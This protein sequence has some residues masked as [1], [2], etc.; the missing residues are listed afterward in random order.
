MLSS[1]SQNDNGNYINGD[2]SNQGMETDTEQ[3]KALVEEKYD[4]SPENK[5]ALDDALHE[6]DQ[7][8]RQIFEKENE[9]EPEEITS[10]IENAQEEYQKK[11]ADITAGAE[12]FEESE[13]DN[14]DDDENNSGGFGGSDGVWGDFF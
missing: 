12:E 8:I 7:K 11:L 4:L 3:D 2:S 9:L 1:K 10:A 13:S 5:K 14:D 6:R